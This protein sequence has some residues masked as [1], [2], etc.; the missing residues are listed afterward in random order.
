MTERIERIEKME[1]LLNRLTAVVHQ[2]NE[3][4]AQLEDSLADL[5]ELTDYYTS[6]LW[7]KDFEAD[8]RGEIPSHI[9]RGVLSEDGVYNMLWEYRCLQDRMDFL[10]KQDDQ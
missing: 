3:A 4:L 8:E 9:R 6:P 10:C 5:K 1:V 2:A 7:M